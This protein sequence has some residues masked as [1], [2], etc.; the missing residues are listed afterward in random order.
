MGDAVIDCSTVREP[1]RVL[2]VC[3]GNLHR[4]PLAERLLTSRLASASGKFRVSSAGTAAVNGTPMDPVAAALL[5][6]MGGDPAGA[7][8]RRL[9]AA[10]V[11]A[12]ALVLGAATEHREAAVRLR[13]VHGLGRAFTLREFARLLHE[14]DAAGLTDPAERA[15]ALTRG[16]A[17]RRGVSGGGR[18]D[19][20]LVD[21][22]GASEGEARACA[23]R[24]TEAVE[25]IAAAVLG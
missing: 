6:E 5:T 1:F 3:T 19:D 15:A 18:W 2:V 24:I 8:A 12:A 22:Y 11:S 17:A 7:T 4:S 20:D 25:R 23:A 14:D 10:T 9:T 13:P 21:P 16:A